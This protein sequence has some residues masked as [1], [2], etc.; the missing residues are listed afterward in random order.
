MI[1]I[2]TCAHKYMHTYMRARICMHY[3][4]YECIHRR[5]S[6]VDSS[7]RR[8]EFGIF[9]QFAHRSETNIRRSVP[10]RIGHTLPIRGTITPNTH[11]F[12]DTLFADE[13]EIISGLGGFH[14]R[15]ASFLPP[16]CEG[17]QGR[18]GA[19]KKGLWSWTVPTVLQYHKKRPFRETH[20]H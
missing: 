10:V 13:V 2:Y 20:H 19:L 14:R 4:I 17:V 15:H 1:D 9:L 16:G 7:S 6:R 8:G 18:K 11:L 3:V 5:W 12:G